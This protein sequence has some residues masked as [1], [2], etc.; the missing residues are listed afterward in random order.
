MSA[1]FYFE[2]RATK[3]IISEKGCYFVMGGPLAMNVDVY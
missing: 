1:I 2:E 3:I